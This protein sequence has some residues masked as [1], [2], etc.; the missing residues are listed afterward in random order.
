M[1]NVL[2]DFAQSTH[3]QVFGNKELIL[4]G[5]DGVINYDENCICVKSNRLKIT[6][7]GAGLRIETLTSKDIALKGLIK[8]INYDYI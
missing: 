5:C 6:I 8:S 2:P 3:L 4:D 1:I 7:E